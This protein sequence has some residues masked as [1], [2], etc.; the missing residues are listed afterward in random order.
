M[1]IAYAVV[2]ITGSIL[3]AT[4]SDSSQGRQSRQIVSILL[5]I[6]LLVALMV[7]FMDE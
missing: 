4:L 2:I 5:A 3:Y 1:Y 6:L 7:V